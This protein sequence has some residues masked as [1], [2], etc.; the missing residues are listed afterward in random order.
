MGGWPSSGKLNPQFPSAA[1]STDVSSERTIDASSEAPSED[2]ADVSAG[3]PSKDSAD[4]SER[5]PSEDSA[6]I[7]A[8]MSD[9]ILARAS[10]A[11][12]LLPVFTTAAMRPRVNAAAKTM[13]VLNIFFQFHCFII[14]SLRMLIF[15][16]YMKEWGKVEGLLITGTGKRMREKRSIPIRKT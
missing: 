4:V 11:G 3:M 7:L 13:A 9:E 15:Y 8:E 16:Q 12:T 2:F 14:D 10:R 6:D 1:V 5:A